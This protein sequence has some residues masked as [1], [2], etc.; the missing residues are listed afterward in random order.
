MKNL[1]VVVSS[2]YII[3]TSFP[4]HSIIIMQTYIWASHEYII[5]YSL[6]IIYTWVTLNKIMTK[7]RFL[8]G[9]CR[10]WIR[11]TAFLANKSTIT[12]INQAF[13]FYSH[14]FQN[15]CFLISGLWR[16][17]H[18]KGS[19]SKGRDY[20]FNRLS[21][22]KKNLCREVSNSQFAWIVKFLTL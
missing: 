17:P 9:Y 8:H 20:Y 22:K 16:Q 12:M 19:I 6:C 1:N 4:I 2:Q 7:E 15:C 13:I 21:F 10:Y 5:K 11:S 14:A 3:N 18:P